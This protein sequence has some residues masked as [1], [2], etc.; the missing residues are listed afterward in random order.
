MREGDEHRWRGVR[1]KRIKRIKC[2]KCIKYK[3]QIILL[4]IPGMSRMRSVN[5]EADFKVGN[6]ARYPPSC[7]Q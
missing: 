1:K 3:V 5:Q 6:V 7:S 4:A 2:I